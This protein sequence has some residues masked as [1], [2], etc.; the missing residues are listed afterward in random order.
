LTVQGNGTN[1]EVGV[2]DVP[3]KIAEVTSMRENVLAK[4]RTI[5]IRTLAIVAVL[6]TYAVG[7]IGTQVATTLGISTLAL[8]TSSTS[9]QAWWRRGWGW[10][11]GGCWRRGWC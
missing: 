8:T 9:A 6:A 2:D 11:R 10:R 7:S 1:V 3:V 4:A 5:V